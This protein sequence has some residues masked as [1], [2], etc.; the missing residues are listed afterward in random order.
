MSS[1]TESSIRIEAPFDLVWTMTNALERW[2]DLFTEYASVEVVER[3]GQTVRFRL[4]MHPDA[5]GKV[6]S[7]VSERT[8]NRPEYRVTA[9]R[10][11]PGPFRYMN[12]LW[13]YEEDGD[14]T[15]MRWI[16]DFAMRPEAPV[17]DE[18]MASHIAA[19][20][21]IQMRVIRAKVEAAYRATLVAP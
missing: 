3:A 21:A 14:H 12:I 15:V 6:W 18:G 13:L 10:V 8:L 17:D 20:S 4:T 16:Q 5:G 7:W 11:E 1:Y 19:N 2:P 9:R